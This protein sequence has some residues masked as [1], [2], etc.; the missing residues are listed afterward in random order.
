[1]TIPWRVIPV[2]DPYISEDDVKAVAGAVR[3]KRLSQGKCVE[4]FEKAFSD[5]LKS[6]QA[7]AVVNGTAALHLALLAVG[8]EPGNE[9]IVP[10][11]TFVASSN[12]V[13]YVGAKPVFV[14]IDPRTFNIDPQKI[15][16]AISPKTKAIV[17]VHYAGQPADLDP[18]LKIAEK[19]CL[20]V[21]EDAAEAHGAMYRNR[22][23]GSIGCVGCFSFYPNKNMTTG[24]G[25][26]IV[27]NSRTI[28][29]KICLLRSHGQDSRYH[30]VMIGYNYRMTDI[31]AALGLAQLRKLDWI[32]RKKQEVA[33]YYDQLLSSEEDIQT[34]YIIQDATH[35]YMFYTVKFR[36]ESIRD[37]VMQHL[38]KKGV[39]T[40]VAFPP[41][42]LQPCYRSLYGYK[43]DYLPITEDCAK[44]VLSLPIYPHIRKEDQD[45][46]AKTVFEAIKK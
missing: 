15:E 18:I 17:V 31:L 38:G 45:F 25:G 39:E 9:V 1:M 29:E 8:V 11:F 46:V 6:S 35:A 19:H 24:E 34:P 12:C 21:I 30:H 27:T 3:N 14:D 23:A 5:Y 10:S 4:K 7:L 22:M 32:L 20:P 28:S 42:H 43:E 37:R 44:R 41:V 40:R 36:S 2:A 16:K 33:K 13:L 26:M